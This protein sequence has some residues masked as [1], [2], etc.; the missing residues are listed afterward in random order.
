MANY[1]ALAKA[2]KVKEI[3]AERNIKVPRGTIGK[4]NT[5]MT[6]LIDKACVRAKK[7]GSTTLKEGHFEEG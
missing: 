3:A 7:E 6:D 1:R 4:I 2:N 5:I